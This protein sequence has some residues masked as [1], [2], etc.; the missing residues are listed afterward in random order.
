MLT[1]KILNEKFLTSF[2]HAI[3]ISEFSNNVSS[4]IPE[5]YGFCNNF[6]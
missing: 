5:N 6:L 3:F 4:L 2:A 1:C